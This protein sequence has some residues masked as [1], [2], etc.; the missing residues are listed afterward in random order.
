M[1]DHDYA[2]DNWEEY[3]EKHPEKFKPDWNIEMI[4]EAVQE[5]MQ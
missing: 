4:I 3:D 2:I 1:D 5:F